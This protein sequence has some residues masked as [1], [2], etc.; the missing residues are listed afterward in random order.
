MPSFVPSLAF[1]NQG[2]Q[3]RGRLARVD[4]EAVVLAG[5]VTA[6]RPLLEAGL[7]LAPVAELELVGVAAGGQGQELVAQA[8]A[9]EGDALAQEP[10]D[11]G[12]RRRRPLRVA[13]AVG[14]DDAARREVQDAAGVRVGRDADDGHAAPDEGADD[15]L[16]DAAVDEDD[17]RLGPG[18]GDADLR[19][20]DLGHEVAGV[21]VGRD[22]GLAAQP[23][24]RSAG[25]RRRPGGRA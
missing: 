25:R 16:L 15:P 3:P 4:G 2:A 9:E 8:D 14:D 23:G 11:G 20:R 18:V 17:G 10:A 12:D 21:G 1:R 19:R 24:E 13:R 22:A 6:L 7:V 5:D